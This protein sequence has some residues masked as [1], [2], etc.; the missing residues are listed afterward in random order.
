M[1]EKTYKTPSGTISYWVNHI[2]PA[3]MSFV[4]LP[5]LILDHRLY[6][7][8]V[9]YFKDKYNVLVWDAPGHG[10]SWPFQ[11]D[12]TLLDKARWLFDILE[13]EKLT[14]PIIVGQSM[15]GFVGQAFS[16]LYPDLLR[17]FISID[18][19]PLQK[20]Y[21]S[22]WG[23]WMLKRMDTIYKLYPWKV[24]V[25]AASI[26][27]AETPYGQKLVYDMKMVYDKDRKRNYRLAGH[28]F[29]MMAQAIEANL[30][31]DLKCP[32]LLL[33]GEQDKIKSIVEVNK[34]WHQESQIPLHWIKNAG[35]NANTDQPEIV[36]HLIESFVQNLE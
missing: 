4:F 30:N 34:T 28:G 13:Q 27:S 3:K 15:G 29:Q 36:N 26:G 35:H 19:A 8:Q 22:S 25:K 2:D 33:C 21:M 11:F 23:L 10:D 7:K 12:Y 31:Y 1:K 18:S 14:K 20:K 24:L 6:D 5:G 32:A 16:E 9:D 17:G